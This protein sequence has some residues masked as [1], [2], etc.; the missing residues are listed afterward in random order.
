MS[1]GH[2][3]NIFV[4]DITKGTKTQHYFNMVRKQNFVRPIMFNH[5]PPDNYLV[6]LVCAASTCRLRD[7]AM[8]PCTTASSPPMASISLAQTLTAT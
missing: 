5:R 3:G 8:E 4:W 1:A 2:D 6:T 7:R